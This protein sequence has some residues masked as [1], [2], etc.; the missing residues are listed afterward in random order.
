MARRKANPIIGCLFLLFFAA[1][2]TILLTSPEEVV[3]A[4]KTLVKSTTW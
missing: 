4:L 2:L 1:V 3:E